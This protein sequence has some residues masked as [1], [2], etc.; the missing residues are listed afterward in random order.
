MH[1]LLK[2]CPKCKNYYLEEE[3]CPKCKER[4]INPNPPRFKPET[5]EK[6]VKGIMNKAD[7]ETLEKI[8][9]TLF[10]EETGTKK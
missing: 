10:K 8:I 7:E 2:K 6:T 9:N 5:I 1:N 4:T 3:T